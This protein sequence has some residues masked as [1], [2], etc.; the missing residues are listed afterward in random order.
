MI[1]SPKFREQFDKIF[2]MK[3]FCRLEEDIYI[4]HYLDAFDINGK[5]YACPCDAQDII[6]K[7]GI[8]PE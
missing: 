6:V 2:P 3:S 8:Q 5:L 1:Q 7:K 4:R